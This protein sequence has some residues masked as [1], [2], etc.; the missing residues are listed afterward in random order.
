MWRKGAVQQDA[1]GFATAFACP[2]TS[3]DVIDNMTYT[4]ANNSNTLLDIQET[5]TN[6]NTLSYVHQKGFKGN[7][8]NVTDYTYD[9]NG[10]LKTD[11]NKNITN[12]TY[13]HL[14]LPKVITFANGNTI[15]WLYD[16]VPSTRD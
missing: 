14:N 10:N 16:A 2:E 9:A 7:T 11:A 4:Y 1:L 6:T 8:P 13:N 3:V 5:H 12:I 15:T